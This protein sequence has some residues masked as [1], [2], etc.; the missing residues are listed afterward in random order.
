VDWYLDTIILYQSEG[1]N[2]I[3]EALPHQNREWPNKCAGISVIITIPCHIVLYFYLK[4]SYP[5]EKSMDTVDFLPRK[6]PLHL[7]MSVTNL[8]KMLTYMIGECGIWKLWW[9]DMQKITHTGGNQ[10]M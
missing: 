7:M 4:N 10:F 5:S 9:N 1:E 3:F 8:V 2:K 6:W